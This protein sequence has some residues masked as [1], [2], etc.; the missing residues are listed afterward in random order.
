MHQ[1]RQSRQGSLRKGPLVVNDRPLLS[2]ERTSNPTETGVVIGVASSQI[3]VRLASGIIGVVV[4]APTNGSG[5]DAPAIG[6]QGIFCV[7]RRREDGEIEVHLVS[8]EWSEAPGSF[9]RD[10]STLRQ[11]LQDHPVSSL[12]HQSPPSIPSMDEQ[13]VQGWV[14]QVDACLET[15]RKN[16]AKRLDEEAPTQP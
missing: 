12:L 7:H 6:D 10:V 3:R 11:A 2:S 8:S 9:D 15:L 16:R 4:D 5:E 13:R 1:V 14:Q